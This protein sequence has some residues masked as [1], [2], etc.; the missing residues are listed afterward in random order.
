[1]YNNINIYTMK[2]Q[3][4]INIQAPCTENFDQFSSTPLG[5]FCNSCEKEVV[6]FTKMNSQEIINYFKTKDPQN[7]CGRFKNNQLK[8]Y[9]KKRKRLSFISGI[10]LA[11]LSFFSTSII[12]AQEIKKNSKTTGNLSEAKSLKSEKSIVVKGTLLDEDGLPLPGASVHL[13]GTPRGTSTNFDGYFE[14]PEKLRQGDVLTFSFIGYTSKKVIIDNKNSAK[15]TF[16]KV[17]MKMDSCILVGKIAVKKVYKS[18][19]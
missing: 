4:S 14:F 2:N 13:E 10:G 7:T 6:D 1:M 17:D 11:C 12:Q 18:K 15:N 5:G 3:F 16:L 19:K 9:N 8:T